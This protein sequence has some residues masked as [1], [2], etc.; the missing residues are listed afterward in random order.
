[1]VTL[2]CLAISGYFV[3]QY[4]TGSLAELGEQGV[5]LAP[6]YASRPFFVQIAFYVHVVSAG[7]SLVVGPFQFAKVIRRRYRAVHRW[8]GRTYVVS[9]A[10][11]SVSGLVMAAFNSAAF[12][13]FF[14]FGTLSVL[15]GWTTWRG[16]RAI[17][18]HDVASHQAWMIR[19]FALTFA[20]VTLRLWLGVLIIFQLVVGFGGPNAEVDQL[21]TDAYAAVPFLCWLPNIVI[22]EIM[23]RR[24]N[25]PGL[26]FSPSPV[27]R[28]TAR[29]DAVPVEV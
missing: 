9:I 26:R 5:G 2:L 27:P 20:A 12:V 16:Y 28:G 14:G 18:E 1:M 24:R 10:F 7:I 17:R 19:S 22:A 13:G 23:I 15:W 21:M 3:G 29:A 25:L 4:A 11:A 8:I 6:T